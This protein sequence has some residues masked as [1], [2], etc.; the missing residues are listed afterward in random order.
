MKT[1]LAVALGGAMGASARYL[2]ISATG[3]WLGDGFPWGTLI[4][5]VAGCFLMGVLSEAMALKW[6]VGLELRALLTIGI[7]GGFT[8]F[9]SFALD[10]ALLNDR[11]EFGA[12]AFYVLASVMLSIGGFYAGLLIVRQSIA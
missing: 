4:V 1:L 2:L 6:N 8:T 7:L 12:S 5:N 9:S 3:R 11:A 10:T